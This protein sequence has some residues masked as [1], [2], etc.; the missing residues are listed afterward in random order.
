[1]A[2]YVAKNG[3]GSE[4]VARQQNRNDPRFVFLFEGGEFCDYYKY[5]LLY[6]IQNCIHF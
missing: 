6:E 3:P 4:E 1:M 2:E 5:R